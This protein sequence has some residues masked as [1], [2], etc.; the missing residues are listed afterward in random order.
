MKLVFFGPPGVGKGTY[1]EI[2]SKEFSIPR[3]SIGDILREKKKENSAAGRQ[4]KAAIDKGEFIDDHLALDIIMKRIKEPDCKNGYILDGYPR[5]ISQADLFKE[6]IDA[7]IS[8]EAKLDVIIDRLS[9]RRVC[10]NPKCNAIYHIR[11]NPPKKEG[12]CDLCR[13]P[14]SPRKDDNEDVIR[15]RFR[16]YEEKTKPLADYYRK[17]KL[18]ISIDANGT[19]EEVGKETIKVLKKLNRKSV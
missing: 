13:S 9:G 19:I 3:I 16:I 15:N 14:L 5:L 4:V 10:T 2:V 8:F 1:A 6:K 11:N 12:I 7:V 17:K 18:L